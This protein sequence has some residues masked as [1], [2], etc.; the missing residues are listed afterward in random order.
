M[1]YK[2]LEL[3]KT[4]EYVSGE[5]IS[6]HFGITRSA[7]WKH[8]GALR[9][10]GFDIASSPGRG[11]RLAENDFINPETLKKYV[12]GDVYYSDCVDSTNAAC[13]R[14][15][16]VS[17]GSV[18]V[19]DTQTGGR[20]RFGRKWSSPKGCA[21]YMSICVKPDIPPERV[22]QLTPVAGMAVCRTIRSSRIKWP[23]D[24][25]IDG[26]K[27]C[28]ILTEITAEA[29]RVNRV[30]IGIGINVN[31]EVFPK[32]LVD[33]ATSLYRETGKRYSRERIICDVLEEFWKLYDI[34]LAEGFSA[35]KREYSLKCVTTGNKV[36]IIKNGKE[37]E[38]VA[39]EIGD[40]G[41]LIVERDG[42]REAVTSGEVSVRGLLGYI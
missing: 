10:A 26:K 8:I 31:N 4:G 28:G 36:R 16:N 39:K 37:Y 21:V 14:A 25:L 9:R 35:L 12:R 19:A 41:E 18:F 22:S 13:K 34:F 1:K 40:G 11:Y 24:V 6:E 29:D 27:V 7:V 42:I 3:L 23:N 38:A 15:E 33:K 32:E 20:G 30:I 17:D 5:E 2:I